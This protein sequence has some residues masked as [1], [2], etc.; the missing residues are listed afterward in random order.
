MTRAGVLSVMSSVMRRNPSALGESVLMGM[1]ALKPLVAMFDHPVIPLINKADAAGVNM[2][3]GDG[4]AALGMYESLYS[5]LS[6]I[7]LEG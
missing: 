1:G 6:S 4:S 5:S 7:F 3:A 2:W